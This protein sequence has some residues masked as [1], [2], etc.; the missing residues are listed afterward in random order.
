MSTHSLNDTLDPPP[1]GAR[2]L[3]PEV[4]AAIRWFDTCTIANAIE[5]FRVRLRNE[6]FTRPGLH[7]LT[8][9]SPPLLGFAQTF[10]IR[11]SDPPMVGNAYFDRID[12]WPEIARL[13][14]PRIAVY[15]DLE[16]GED[17]SGSVAGEVHAA[18]L[19]AFGCEGIITNGAVRDI[20]ALRRMR[21]T[22]FARTVAVSHAYNHIVEFGR[23]VDVFGL[24][25]R[26]GELLYADV[27]GA[28]SIPLEVAPDLPRVAAEIR[29]RERRV[30]DLCQSSGFTP[31]ALINLIQTGSKE[32]Q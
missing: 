4:L 26:P 20:P 16:S 30:I 3:D 17:G 10:Q 19:R 9:D 18:I 15:E 12:W 1:N 25:V 11:S 31:K 24:H 29:A 27:H 5:K 22:V 8:P 7:C 6:G 14:L 32:D 2:S 23:P 21:F 13:P 28:V